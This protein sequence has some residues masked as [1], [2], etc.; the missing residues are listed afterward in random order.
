MQAR[1][2]AALALTEIFT[3]Q[4]SL[5]VIL[6]DYLNKA[7]IDKD[8][9]F[10]QELCYGVLRWFYQLDF[11]LQAMLEKDLRSKDTDIKILILLGLYQ[12]KFLRTP[13]HAAVSA[14]VEAC[15]DLNKQ[16]AKK[17]VNALLRR[18][19]EDRDQIE[20]LFET[21]LQ[22]KYAHPH[23][24][25]ESL[26]EEYPDRWETILQENNS[27]P[28]MY[29]RVNT[30]LTT[31]ADYMV[32]LKKINIMATET[33]L[34]ESGIKLSKAMDVEQLPHFNDGH[35]SVQGLAAQLTYPLLHIQPGQRVLDAC[36][37]PGGK[38]AHIL[39]QA[40]ELDE[41]VAL[42][43][44]KKRFERMQHTLS[45]T[46]LMATLVCNDAQATDQWW[47][48]KQ[49]DRILLDAPC[50]ATGVIR[51]HPDIKI[52]RKAKNIA[53]QT[54]IQRKLLAALW[55]LLTRGGKLLYV[56][57]SVLSAENDKCIKV[58]VNDHLDAQTVMIN[59]EWGQTTEYGRQIVPGENDMDGFYYACLEKT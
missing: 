9:P 49:F 7:S 51:R 33:S 6:P 52:L 3:R 39:E 15:A 1:A 36:A 13:P 30:K 35:V 55:P 44:D 31:R 24:L 8:R 29:L 16:W 54:N 46:Q 38:L 19:Q 11:V 43:Q 10:I 5:S 32:E 17:L 53:I 50:S 59:T 2:I 37:A 27:Y 57:C 26:Q 56:T 34:I 42:E 18:Y 58:F 45:R 4:L 48:G 22:A 21:D 40:P 47:D 12:L 23:W 25:I 20:K 28:P 41:V 14:T